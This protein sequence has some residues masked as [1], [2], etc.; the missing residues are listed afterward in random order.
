M[1]GFFSSSDSQT[2][3]PIRRMSGCGA[4]KLHKNCLSPRMEPTGK[5]EKGILIIAEAPGKTED[6]RNT[7][8]VGE[9]GQLL[10]RKLRRF[11]IDLDRDCRKTNAVCCRPEGNRTPTAFEVECCRPRVWREIETFQPKLILLLGG[12][13]VQS[14]L[15]HRWKKDLGGIFKWRGWQIPDRD[16][17]AWVAP[18]FHPSYIGRLKDNPAIDLTFTDDLETALSLLDQ[19]FPRYE[20]EEHGVELLESDARVYEKLQMIYEWHDFLAID[21]ETTG[22]KPQAAGHE[23]LTCSITVEPER[24]YAFN[25]PT[26]RKTQAMFR[27][28]LQEDRIRKTGHN[29]KYEDNWFNVILGTPVES[30]FWD[31]MLAAHILDNRGADENSDNKESGVK[32][33]K[34]QTYVNFGLMDYSSHLDQYM[35]SDTKQFGGNGFNRNREAS[36]RELLL[37]NGVDTIVQY[38]LALKQM[39]LLGVDL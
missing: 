9:A 20:K 28:I 7:Q 29:I 17:R 5:G 27:R 32:G 33:L 34:F 36:R 16:T 11:G 37:Y 21:I 39:K 6:E 18:M 13:A 38:R 3:E 25:F 26:D 31:S 12:A 14:F 35:K 24:A 8:L 1:D 2:S 19:P 4:C 15:A 10:R 23:I 30:W 22:L